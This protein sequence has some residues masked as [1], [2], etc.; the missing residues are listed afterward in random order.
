[1]TAGFG[2]GVNNVKGRILLGTN[3]SPAALAAG[4]WAAV[5]AVDVGDE[6]VLAHSVPARA[7]FR[8]ED[9]YESARKHGQ[10][11]L[12]GEAARLSAR[13]PHLRLAS[14]LADGEVA[15]VMRGLS[16]EADLVV[17]GTDR[18]PD[19]HGEGFGSVS[20]QTS[21]ISQCPVTVVPVLGQRPAAGVVVG[22]D[23]SL[24]S[25]I[26]AEHAAAEANR[27]GEDLTIVHAAR[28]ISA[29]REILSAAKDS[30]TAANPGLPVHELL[31][32][33]HGPAEALLKAGLGARLLVLGCR[34]KGGLRV[35][36]GSVAKD[37]LFKIHCPTLVTRPAGTMA[38]LRTASSRD[39][40][41]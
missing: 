13:H 10:E 30:V 39:G 36:I 21:I 14:V 2:Q 15:Q 11:L 40:A 7:V 35:L 19:A 32:L 29:G 8:V 24:E 34:G 3:G 4:D 28:D 37:V 9:S 38:G 20:F 1:M 17:V 18:G 25:G 22:V 27:L 31:D 33:D 41:P 12:D 26:A 6:L 16:E 5:R 23:G